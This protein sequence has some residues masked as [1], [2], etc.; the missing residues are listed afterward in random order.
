VYRRRLKAYCEENRIDEAD[1]T[2]GVKSEIMAKAKSMYEE[3]LSGVAGRKVVLDR[4]LF[5]PPTPGG[6][7]PP[8]M[9][10]DESATAEDD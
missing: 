9:A 7:A 6:T 4:A 8:A 3:F 10:T 5:E 2:K 1:L